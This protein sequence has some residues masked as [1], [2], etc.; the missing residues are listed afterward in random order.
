[1]YLH[2]FACIRVYLLVS[3]CICMYMFLAWTKLVKSKTY[4]AVCIVCICMYY[5][6]MYMY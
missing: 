1:M 6:C 3:V 2:V 5:A 4:V